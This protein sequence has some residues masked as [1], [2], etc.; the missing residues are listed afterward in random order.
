MNTFIQFL[1]D[2]GYYLLFFWVLLEQLG[3]P[4]PTAPLLL[5]AGALAH[6]GRLN[7]ALVLG[8]AVTAAILSDSCWYQ[9]GRLRGKKALSFVCRIS[10]D[11]DSCITQA[12]ALL[13]RHGGRLLLVAKFIPGLNA[14][15]T[16]SAG[17]ARMAFPK[18]L[19]MDGLGSFFW[20]GVFVGAGY[21]FS[22]DI[23]YIAT[24]LGSLGAWAALVVPGSLAAYIV[25]KYFRRRSFLRQLSVLRITPEEVKQRLDAGDRLMILDVRNRDEIREESFTLP[26]AFSLPLA[27]LENHHQRIPRDHDV[28]LYC[29]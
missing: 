22:S 5:A 16:P 23:E 2:H 27:E 19:L 4:I 10:L 8:I 9:I 12:R 25:W 14:L 28:I 7:L 15:A 20:A 26:G 17:T 24:R 21:L 18:F 1:I 6:G 29:A 3:L 13:A 11:R